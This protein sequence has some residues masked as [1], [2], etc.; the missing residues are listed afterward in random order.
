MSE[1]LAEPDETISEAMWELEETGIQISYDGR[2]G[3]SSSSRP[4][5]PQ[6]LGLER[7]ARVRTRV[8]QDYFRSVLLANYGAPA[9]SRE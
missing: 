1:Y 6:Q 7:A 5:R 3:A 2:I 8:N 4:D 9:A